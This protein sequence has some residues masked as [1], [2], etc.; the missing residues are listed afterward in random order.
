MGLPEVIY[1][2][3]IQEYIFPLSRTKAKREPH[4]NEIPEFWRLD[5][6]DQSILSEAAGIG[7]GKR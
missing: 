1:E 3:I 4:R 2:L 7:N 5:T 6:R